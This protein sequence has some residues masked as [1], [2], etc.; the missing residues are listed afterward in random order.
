MITLDP[1][2]VASALRNILQ[3][4]PTYG[5]IQWV[6]KHF[7]ISRPT[8]YR[9]R[10]AFLKEVCQGPGRGSKSPHQ[11]QEEAL[12]AEQRQMIAEF[13]RQ[14][15][16]M[17]GRLDRAKNRALF[18]LI[19]RG[20]SARGI[21]QFLRD[22]FEVP[23]NRTDIL[24]MTEQYAMRATELMKTHFWPLATDVD[25]DE[26]FVEGD[27]LYIATDP[28][29]MAI[30]KTAME[31]ERTTDAWSRFLQDLPNLS[32]TTSDRGQA[33]LGAVQ[34]RSSLNHQSDTFHL[35]FL[36][37][38]ELNIMEKRCYGLIAQ[39]A[40]LLHRQ[41]KTFSKG[42]DGRK[43]G[44]WCRVIKD[45]TA[46]AI[47]QFD[48]IEQAVHVAFDALRLTTAQKT[49]NTSTRARESLD[50]ARICINE[51]IPKGWKR[52]KSA[53]QD[54]ALFTFLDEL[55][56]ALPA[57]RVDAVHPGDRESIL[58]SLAWFWEQQAPHRYRGRP[59]VIPQSIEQDLLT[60]CR[61]LPEV[62]RTLFGLLDSIHRASSA[63][64]C[65]NSR[66]GFY[67]YSKR[68]FSTDFANLIAIWHNLTP[69]EDG[70]RAHQCPARILGA[71]LP[72][73]D[74]FELFDVA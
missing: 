6:S 57:I 68:R 37:H 52:V 22:C 23:A 28:K 72:S 44:R 67:R 16:Q 13:Q 58:V 64:E 21:G 15:E 33:I 60:R 34:K 49:F 73:Y 50:L 32:R 45:K 39:E 9:I 3:P 19:A 11:R 63:V 43:L 61:N 5:R 59:V 25:L 69:F 35:K 30:V 17:Q 36:L 48:E 42:R 27:P 70:K 62:K 31:E 55:H 1:P 71:K 24:A 74:I 53:L 18:W 66:V 7:G 56:A 10:N 12:Q 54:P 38:N 40:E 47:A 29:S 8:L 65:I 4:Q 46:V 26:I 41:N 20:L 51:H 14:L 2:I